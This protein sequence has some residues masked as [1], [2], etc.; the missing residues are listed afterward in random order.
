MAAT[1]SGLNEKSKLAMFSTIRAGRTV[2]TGLG[3]RAGFS[4]VS[5]GSWAAAALRETPPIGDHDWRRAEILVRVAQ[6]TL[7]E[8]RIQVDLIDGRH[9]EARARRLSPAYRG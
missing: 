6:V 7:N 5:R 9:T 8:Q 2:P 1:S 3:V 4:R